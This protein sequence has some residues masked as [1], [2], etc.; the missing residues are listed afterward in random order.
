MLLS[1]MI[2]AFGK[3]SQSAKEE[4]NGAMTSNF[5]MM[6]NGTVQTLPQTVN[7]D[8]ESEGKVETMP[9][10]VGIGDTEK[11][12]VDAKPWMNPAIQDILNPETTNPEIDA[13]TEPDVDIP[14]G[15]GVVPGQSIVDSFR[16]TQDPAMK[17]AMLAEIQKDVTF[18]YDEETKTMTISGGEVSQHT[19]DALRAY[20][21]L[22]DG[23]FDD[24]NI[25]IGQDVTFRNSVEKDAL[26][27]YS[28]TAPTFGNIKCKSIDVQSQNITNGDHMFEGTCASIIKVADQPNLESADCMFSDSSAKLISIGEFPDAV[29]NPEGVVC[30]VFVGCDSVVVNKDMTD[31]KYAPSTSHFYKTDADTM[32]YPQKN[33][34]DKIQ[35]N[36]EPEPDYSVVGPDYATGRESSVYLR[37]NGFGENNT[38]RTVDRAQQAENELGVTVGQTDVFQEKGLGE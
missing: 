30:T 20:T 3:S 5:P 2:S 12:V 19:L 15:I 22:S 4:Q 1:S 8:G 18:A 6:D 28:V 32:V 25:V 31:I 26:G 38:D 24:A 23:E 11:P 16:P 37:Q 14:D 36:K 17:E 21:D 13:S 35:T 9:S 10:T 34:E 7:I 27:R 29:M 33:E